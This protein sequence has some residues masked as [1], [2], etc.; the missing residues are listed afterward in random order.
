MEWNH[1]NYTF[2][3]NLRAFGGMMFDYLGCGETVDLAEEV[4]TGAIDEK[5]VTNDFDFL[6]EV[7][8]IF[9]CSGFYNEIIAN[10]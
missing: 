8:T 10:R 9:E 3:R 6:I 4:I 5:R 1:C 7:A 2:D